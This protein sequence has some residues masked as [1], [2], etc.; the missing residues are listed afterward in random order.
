MDWHFRLE[1]Q[2]RFAP[3][4]SSED[5]RL[6]DASEQGNL[7]PNRPYLSAIPHC[8]QFPPIS[9]PAKA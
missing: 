6:R 2:T 1:A 3:N 4:R 5:G 8:P 7:I 9:L